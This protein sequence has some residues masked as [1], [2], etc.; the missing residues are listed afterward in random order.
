MESTKKKKMPNLPQF[1]NIISVHIHGV[2]NIERANSLLAT[3]PTN[4]Y[5][6]LLLLKKNI[7]WL[8]CTMYR[9]VYLHNKS[10]FSKLNFRKETKRAREK[11]NDQHEHLILK[12][13]SVMQTRLEFFFLLASSGNLPYF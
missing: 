10:T 9:I 4:R 11:E 5:E 2:V 7:L 1:F 12:H 8:G 3:F 13:A 6:L